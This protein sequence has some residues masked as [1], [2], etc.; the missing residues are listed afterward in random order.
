MKK[1]KGRLDLAAYLKQT[2]TSPTA[3][4]T[5]T[6]RDNE[7]DMKTLFGQRL[8]KYFSQGGLQK[9][10]TDLSEK[11]MLCLYS[12]MTNS[13]DTSQ[14][15]KLVASRGFGVFKELWHLQRPIK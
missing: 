9:A 8:Q 7:T 2:P 11:A 5:T 13:A 3:K 15:E 6:A 10:S 14:L 4:N 12:I 1:N